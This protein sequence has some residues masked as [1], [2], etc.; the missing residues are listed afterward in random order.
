VFCGLKL[1]F[2]PA[3]NVAA[4]SLSVLGLSVGYPL[5]LSFIIL[6]LHSA[7]T[8]AYSGKHVPD[9]KFS[10][11]LLFGTFF[12]YVS[13]GPVERLGRMD[14]PL[15]LPVRPTLNDLR[16]GVALI[17]LGLVKKIV[18]ANRLK[19]YV[20]SV[21]SGDL[22][23]SSPTVVFAIILNAAY[24]YCDFS[25]YTDIA[26][27]AAR[28]LGI[29]VQINFDRP[30]GARSVTEFWRRW[31]ISFSTWLRDYLYMP[32]AFTLR[33]F[34]TTGTSLSLLITFALCGFW[35]RA[36][37]TFLLF[38]LLHGGAMVA[39][40]RFV[41]GRAIERSR[42]AKRWRGIAAHLSTLIFLAATIVLFSAR[43][44]LQARQIFQRALT[45]PF[46]PS[47]TEVAAY[48]G[49]V[50]FGIMLLS[51]VAWRAFDTWRRRLSPRQTPF[52]LLLAGWAILFLGQVDGGGF[53]YAQF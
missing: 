9:G 3:P 2:E 29:E 4:T 11:F 24:V 27:G 1:S 39:E 13:A 19:P 8:D 44:L 6:M 45:G 52:F 21:F 30:F 5:G 26:R 14:G 40:L 51:I 23:N 25:G 15:D 10:T 48:K 47:S 12:P 50:M 41:S 33:R 22:P 28:C 20:D 17:A 49:A 37:W 46:L 7:V 18:T 38:G 34:R 16:E 35:H 36:A 31:H 53:V 32:I 43:D 42:S